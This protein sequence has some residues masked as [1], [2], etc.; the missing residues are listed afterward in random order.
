MGV[1]LFVLGLLAAASGGL[2]LRAR[3]RS[4]FGTSRLALWETA[5]GVLTVL[6]SGVG[7]A[8]V[9]PL[10][11]PVVAGAFI[12]IVVSSTAHVRKARRHQEKQEASEDARLASHLQATDNS[13]G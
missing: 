10:A 8:D 2:K 1:L 3:V 9:R 5:V 13:R 12:L 6:G 4:L 7:L 11:W